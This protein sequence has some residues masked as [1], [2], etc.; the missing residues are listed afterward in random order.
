MWPSRFTVTEAALCWGMLM[1]GEAEYVRS[2]LFL[3]NFAI[4]FK[5]LYNM[6]ISCSTK[7]KKKKKG[8]QKYEKK[9]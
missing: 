6:I 2:L 8:F 1:L 5:L 7:K 9:Y 3:L 4:S